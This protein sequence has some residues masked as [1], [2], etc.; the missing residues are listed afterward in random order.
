M[1]WSLDTDPLYLSPAVVYVDGVFHMW[2]ASSADV[3]VHATSEDGIRWS[4]L[5][6][7]DVTPPPW[8]LDVAYVGG[9]YVMLLVDSPLAGAN[10]RIATSKDG[11]NWTAGSEPV[12]R[13]GNGWDDERIYRSTL[14]FDDSTR[15]LRLWYSARS[16][17]GQWH[18]GYTQAALAP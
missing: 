3:T 7:V 1:S 14:L 16:S 17:G 2:M 12:L 8:H 15:L 11:S 5:E 4:P 18:V 9:E 13:P 6:T 10:L